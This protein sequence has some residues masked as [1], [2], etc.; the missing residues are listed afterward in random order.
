MCKIGNTTSSLKHITCGVPQ[1]SNLGALLFLIYINDLP[2]CLK[3]SIPAMYADDTSLSVF[4]ES[5]SD[6][7]ISLESVHVWLTANKL[8]LNIEKTEYVIIG[9]YKRISGI[10]NDNESVLNL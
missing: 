5:T 3:T 9:S 1:G 6:A 10:L 4:V 7:N 2:N 8:T